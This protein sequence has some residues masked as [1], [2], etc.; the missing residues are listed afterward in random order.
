LYFCQA[1]TFPPRC[2]CPTPPDSPSSSPPAA[3][4]PSV[5][6]SALPLDL[7][8]SLRRSFASPICSCSSL[9]YRVWACRM[10]AALRASAGPLWPSD[11][12]LSGRAMPTDE[13][14]PTVTSP[15][16]RLL[17]TPHP[18]SH[19][20]PASLASHQQSFRSAVRSSRLP[21][22]RMAD[23]SPSTLSLDPTPTTS[24]LASS[25]SQVGDGSSLS[26]ILAATA[27]AT[28]SSLVAS[29]SA[30]SLPKPGDKLELLPGNPIVRLLS[31]LHQELAP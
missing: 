30:S 8:L 28:I 17:S 1:T 12:S 4:C 7:T 22:R 5:H 19:Q 23:A 6:L 27:S 11:V 3:R 16:S 13:R 9:F 21:K 24:A 10:R 18:T 20:I 25:S 26:D 29:A 15:A 2:R 31:S 14:P